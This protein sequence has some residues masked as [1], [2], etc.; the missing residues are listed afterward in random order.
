[1]LNNTSNGTGVTAAN[2]KLIDIDI[3]QFTHRFATAIGRAR[4]D[5]LDALEDYLA[6]R[7][8]AEIVANFSPDIITTTLKISDSP[9]PV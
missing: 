3:V 7:P 4:V 1:M 9:T 2:R 5:L 8:Q 6:T